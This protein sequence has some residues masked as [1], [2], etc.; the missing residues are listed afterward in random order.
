MKTKVKICRSIEEFENLV[1]REDIEVI[2][3]DVKGCE[4]SYHFQ[5]SF[6]GAV[7]YK[8]KNTIPSF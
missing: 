6:I 4:Q 8:L 5:E 3:M 2:Q 1:N 7:L